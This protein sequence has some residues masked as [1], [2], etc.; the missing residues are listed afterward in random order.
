MKTEFKEKTLDQNTIRELKANVAGLHRHW[1]RPL[2]S[3]LMIGRLIGIW[4]SWNYLTKQQLV[5]VLLAWKNLM[6]R[7]KRGSKYRE[8]HQ[9]SEIH[10]YYGNKIYKSYLP[11]QKL[12]EAREIAAEAPGL[13]VAIRKTKRCIDFKW[14]VECWH[15]ESFES[16]F[17]TI[18]TTYSNSGSFTEKPNNKNNPF[19]KQAV[20]ERLEAEAE[21]AK[22]DLFGEETPRENTI[23]NPFNFKSGN[24]IFVDKSIDEVHRFLELTDW[25]IQ[26][27]NTSMKNQETSIAIVEN[28]FIVTFETGKIIKAIVD[29]LPDKKEVFKVSNTPGKGWFKEHIEGVVDKNRKFYNSLI[30]LA[31]RELNYI[32]F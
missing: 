30:E 12:W 25:K 17:S 2:L 1:K 31:E 5:K 29:I 9:G 14:E 18:S 22:V 8:V 20:E 13:W 4:K 28:K 19:T 10:L 32:P 11:A 23:I 6:K 16:L 7:W 21:A 15:P 24:E 3:K 27:M 26:S